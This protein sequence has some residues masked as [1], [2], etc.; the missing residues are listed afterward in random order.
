MQ[1]TTLG[2]TGLKVSVAGLG[3]GGAS[4]L[5]L[6]RGKTDKDAADLVRGALDLGINLIDAAR[7]Y[8]TEEVVGNALKGVPR[9]SVVLC[10]KH[11]VKVEGRTY[12]A[13]EVVAGLN[14]SLR[15]LRTDH[16]DIF[17]IHGLAVD[18]Y[19]H[20]MKTVLPALRREQEKGKFRFLAAS[21]APTQ[22][23]RHEA[24]VKALG[25]DLFDVFMLA[26]SLVNQN[27]RELVFPKT[28]AQRVG[29][30]LMFVVR[31]IF[32]DKAHLRRSFQALADKGELPDWIAK[33]DDPL[34]FLI[35]VGGARSHTDAA[36]RY[37]RHEPGADVV[38]FGTGSIEHMKENVASILAPPLPEADR[39][40][41]RELFGKLV[42]V[43]LDNHSAAIPK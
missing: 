2:R 42:G 4:R 26:F 3:C 17:Y 27:A 8:G 29:T 6:A 41:I 14:E 40:Q 32:S 38:L 21:E 28:L 5:G 31:G 22:E 34:D 16:V 1:Y 23:P 36:Y 13:D 39:A 37:A 10:T 24:T 15:C 11:L 20:A 35:H 33:K 19:D 12:S 43:G 7:N 25:E 9:D 30:T 18:R